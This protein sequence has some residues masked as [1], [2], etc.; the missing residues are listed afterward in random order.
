MKKIDV[1][2]LPVLDTKIVKECNDN[3]SFY[4]YERVGIADLEPFND[5]KPHQTM[6][7][8]YFQ[9][10]GDLE[11]EAQNP[12]SDERPMHQADAGSILFW[13]PEMERIQAIIVV[14]GGRRYAY[15][16]SST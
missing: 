11:R 13:D 16:L 1:A 10:E 7:T 12:D 14:K 6:E 2:T 4:A 15:E 5:A 3:H 8:F 9:T